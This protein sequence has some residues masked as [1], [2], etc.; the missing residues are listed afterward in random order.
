MGTIKYNAI[1]IAKQLC[2][3][4]NVIEKIKNATTENEITRILHTAREAME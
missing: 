3:S 2:Y 1:R 4:E